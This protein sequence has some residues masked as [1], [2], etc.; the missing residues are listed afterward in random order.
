MYAITKYF[1]CIYDI[2]RDTTGL[3]IVCI[4]SYLCLFWNTCAELFVLSLY[5]GIRLYKMYSE[6]GLPSLF[7]YI[8]CVLYDFLYIHALC[9][10][11]AVECMTSCIV[12]RHG[13]CSVI[14]ARSSLY[15][16][17]LQMIFF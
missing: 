4:Q 11:L 15:I 9:R 5:K 1:I 12:S 6:L 14:P 8:V 13:V 10:I 2:C 16:I 7:M 17:Y 3:C